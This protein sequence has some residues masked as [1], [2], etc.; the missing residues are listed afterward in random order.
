MYRLHLS[1]VLPISLPPSSSLDTPLELTRDRPRLFL[2]PRA[3]EQGI[4]RSRGERIK[5]IL[6]F[7]MPRSGSAGIR[8]QVPIVMP[9]TARP[10][11]PTTGP[12]RNAQ[13]P[14]PPAAPGSFLFFSPCPGGSVPLLL[15]ASAFAKASADESARMSGSNLFPLLPPCSPRFFFFICGCFFRRCFP[16]VSS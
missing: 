8:G 5:A 11:T 2:P 4:L 3:P 15:R 6:H 12:G 1:M 7:D 10:S 16:A 13:P 9:A 14:D